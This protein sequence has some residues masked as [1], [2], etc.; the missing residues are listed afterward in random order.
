MEADHVRALAS[1]FGTVTVTRCAYRA[2]G[3]GNLHPVDAVLN[4]PAEKHSHG[5]R[6]LAA[7]E[8]TRGS[9]TE[10]A[11]AVQR[12]AGVAVGKRQLEALAAATAVDFEAFYA[13]RCPP[14]AEPGDV[15]VLSADGKGV[16]MRPDA[17]RPATAKAAQG[18][19]TKLATRLS[20]GEK[21]NRK[22]M[23]EL[24]AVYDL[25]PLPRSPADILPT[26]ASTASRPAP[27]AKN[28]WLTA[29]VVH[30]AATVIAAAFTEAER[31]D[32]AHARTWVALVD[33]N[34]HQIERIHAEAKARGVTVTIL[35][36]F[37]HVL[38]YL[39]GAAWCFHAEGDPAAEAWVAGK[40]RA[41]LDGKAGIVAA[42]IRRTAT[43]R[44]L[45]RA[46][47]AKADTAADYL[48]RKRR[49]LDYPAA[50]RAGWPITTGII[51]GACRH[52]VCDRMALT[53]ARWGLP[54]AEAILKLRAI[55]ANGEWAAYWRYHLEQEHQRVH[56]TRY[57]G[58]VI[59][60]AAVA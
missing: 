59:P 46:A 45:P 3:V 50:L 9:Y 8:A 35:I 14:A 54:G 19:T 43:C 28:K 42:A 51:E 48:H 55:R 29:S 2:K 38:E 4:L 18:A 22:R 37:V 20:K 39:W 11:A 47:R 52:I 21:R 41:V 44:K 32:P 60:V 25:T 24:A 40:A 16:V 56:A 34:N 26:D 36:D 15:L 23:A 12:A 5:L 17:L 49:H 1:V 30:D 33:G 58:G 31:R 13:Q 27:A 57:Y 6:A 7:V 53:G 10:A